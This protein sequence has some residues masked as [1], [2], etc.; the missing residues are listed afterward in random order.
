MEVCRPLGEDSYDFSHVGRELD[1]REQAKQ[2][3][4]EQDCE[5]KASEQKQTSVGLRFWTSNHHLKVV[6]FGG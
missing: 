1:G 6:H 2:N 4:D 5:Y 3:D